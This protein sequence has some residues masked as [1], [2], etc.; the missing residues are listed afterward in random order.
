MYAGGGEES[1]KK[2][3]F[4][5][6]NLTLGEQAI[7]FINSSQR[8][9]ICVNNMSVE[10]YIKATTTIMA[11]KKFE[12]VSTEMGFIIEKLK[13]ENLSLVF[14][15]SQLETHIRQVSELNFK[16]EKLFIEKTPEELASETP[17]EKESHDDSKKYMM[18]PA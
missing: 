15:T 4:L 9:L 11:W 10:Q 1:A 3:Q 16:I 7:L 18:S 8:I 14:D 5:R 2:V 12:E 17:A 6:Q 13:D